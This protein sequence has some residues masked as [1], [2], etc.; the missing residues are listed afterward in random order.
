MAYIANSL[1]QSLSDFG[2]LTGNIGAHVKEASQKA[3]KRA[4]AEMRGISDNFRE[5]L[6]AAINESLP[7]PELKEAGKAFM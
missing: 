6:T 5:N 4:A 1:N 7:L 2:E 3:M